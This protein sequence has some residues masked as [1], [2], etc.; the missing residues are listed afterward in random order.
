LNPDRALRQRLREW[1]KHFPEILSKVICHNSSLTAKVNEFL[2]DN[3][4]VGPKEALQGPLWQSLQ[5][6]EGALRSLRAIK[7]LCAELRDINV[8]LEQL[9]ES[10][11][12]VRREVSP[13]QAFLMIK[14]HMPSPFFICE[15]ELTANEI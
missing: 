7:S 9:K 1:R 8:H 12:E 3:G 2:A 5:G 14:L 11:D 15:L 10:Y 4:I 6:D 13:I